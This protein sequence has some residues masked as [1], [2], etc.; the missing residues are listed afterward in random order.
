[1]V[2]VETCGMNIG[3]TDG[4]EKYEWVFPE[5]RQLRNHFYDGAWR[6]VKARSIRRIV[7]LDAPADPVDQPPLLAPAQPRD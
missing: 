1:M 2:G 7:V 3:C 5:L 4:L 6:V